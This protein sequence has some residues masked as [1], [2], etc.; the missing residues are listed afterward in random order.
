MTASARC[1]LS[2]GDIRVPS[3][4]RA[5]DIKTIESIKTVDLL[6]PIAARAAEHRWLCSLLCM[7]AR[8]EGA[9]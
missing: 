5:T 9:R 6:N 1:T 2:T 8:T 4:K 7:C 3:G